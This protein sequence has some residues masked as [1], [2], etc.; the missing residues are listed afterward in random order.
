VST[1]NLADMKAA[2][3]VSWIFFDMI[4]NCQHFKNAG[5]LFVKKDTLRNLNIL[6]N[7]DRIWR[8]IRVDISL[9]TKD[10]QNIP[11]NILQNVE[12]ASFFSEV[13][14]EN[15]PPFP[16][17]SMIEILKSTP[18]ISTLQLDIE[19]F[20]M[21]LR[22]VLNH[23]DVRNNLKSLKRLEIV[24]PKSCTGYKNHTFKVSSRNRLDV[25]FSE[26]LNLLT[27][28]LDNLESF[29][30]TKVEFGSLSSICIREGVVMLLQ[31]N[32]N[33]LQ[34][35]AVHLAVWESTKLVGLKI[36]RL[37][38]LTATTRRQGQETLE[39]FF[40][41][42]PSLEELDIAVKKDFKRSLFNV[43]RERSPNLRKLHLKAK[44]FVGF[45]SIGRGAEWSFLSEMTRLRDF[46]L[47]RPHCKDPKWELYGNGVEILEML[48]QN[49]LERLG[50][51]GIGDKKCGFWTTRLIIGD[52][53][54]FL[55][56]EL[57][58][59]YKLEVLRGFRNLKRLSFNRCPD[60]VDDDVMRFIV[61]EMTSLEELEVS[62]CSRL[63]NAGIAGVSEEGSDSIRNLKGG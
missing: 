22:V 1:M 47:S 39:R 41:D 32:R 18:K 8:A 30:M 25:V 36:P 49:Q 35:I 56:P 38:S 28:F 26:N 46:Q 7:S 58:L 33:T 15:N 29:C 60:A 53:V 34:E 13:G 57:E 44:K 51:R 10:L 50:F 2:R 52:R 20:K 11:R 54:V 61:S 21:S 16:S 37:T 48:P 43:I 4:E 55:E 9:P 3:Q 59:P 31:K 24:Y 23:N 45:F 63:T 12:F 6:S 42:H 19:V 62:H 17:P 14:F 27:T 5:V 40:I